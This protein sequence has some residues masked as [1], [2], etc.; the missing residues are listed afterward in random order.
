MAVPPFRE[1][2]ADSQERGGCKVNASQPE[3]DE[4]Y[5]LN[6]LLWSAIGILQTAY[7]MSTEPAESF[8]R[9]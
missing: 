9:T 3:P 5:F 1:P 6:R 4:F 7:T 8:S 2:I